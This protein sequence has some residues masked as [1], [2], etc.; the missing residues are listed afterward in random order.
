MNFL[1]ALSVSFH[2]MSL[3]AFPYKLMLLPI[4]YATN[5]PQRREILDIL[6]LFTITLKMHATI[7]CVFLI[8]VSHSFSQP[9]LELLVR[10][11]PSG[12]TAV[13]LPI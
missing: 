12:P 13:G 1:C 7:F 3:C 5:S 2:E 11:A 6:L 10:Q 9:A 8:H 4:C